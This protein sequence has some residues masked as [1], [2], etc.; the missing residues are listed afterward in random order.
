MIASAAV[1]EGVSLGVTSVGDVINDLTTIA[2]SCGG[3]NVNSAIAC[4]SRIAMHMT[5]DIGPMVN[6]A[7]KCFSV[8]VAAVKV[9]T[10]PDGLHP[11]MVRSRIHA[12]HSRGYACVC[13]FF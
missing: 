11:Q 7:R 9:S 1:I 8:I 13:V 2:L 12:A 4:M 10:R 5:R 6:L 3:S